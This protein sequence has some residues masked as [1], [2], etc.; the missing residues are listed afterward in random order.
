MKKS[1][2]HPDEKLVKAKFDI[3]GSKPE[4][5]ILTYEGYHFPGDTWNGWELPYFDK[6]T[7]ERLLKEAGYK[8]K[9]DNNQ[10]TIINEE[11]PDEPEIVT[12]IHF[13]VDGKQKTL[14]PFGM[15]WTWSLHNKMK[16]GGDVN[17]IY[18]KYNNPR[19]YFQSLRFSVSPTELRKIIIEDFKMEHISHQDLWEILNDQN[20]FSEAQAYQVYNA[21]GYDPPT[22]FPLEKPITKKED[23][24]N[25]PTSATLPTPKYRYLD[26]LTDTPERHELSIKDFGGRPR[27]YIVKK[28]REPE[29]GDLTYNKNANQYRYFVTGMIDKMPGEILGSFSG[30]ENDFQLY[31]PTK[32]ELSDLIQY[33][34]KR[35]DRAV[36]KSG[37]IEATK[38]ANDLKEKYADIL[39]QTQNT[40]P[41]ISQ[42]NKKS[43][44]DQY[45]VQEYSL[46]KYKPFETTPDDKTF[47][48]IHA[49]FAASDDSEAR[50]ALFG[51]NF[52]KYGTVSTDA[53]KLLFSKYNTPDLAKY[54]NYCHTEKCFRNADAVE[55]TKYP[56]WTQIIP[57]NH[58]IKWHINTSAM[59]NFLKNVIDLQLINQ[60]TKLVALTDGENTIG[61]NAKN[62]LVAIEALVKL[63]HTDLEIAWS[64]PTGAALIYPKGNASKIK[65]GFE[66]DGTI[67]T[68]TFDT[69]F[70][71][72]MPVVLSTSGSLLSGDQTY[73]QQDEPNFNVETNCVKLTADDAPYCFDL[74]EI[75]KNK[76]KA[77]ADRLEAE[78]KASQQQIQALKENTAELNNTLAAEKA[79][80]EAKKKALADAADLKRKQEIETK[81]LGNIEELA[82]KIKTKKQAQEA[83]A[84]ART[85]SPDEMA[86]TIAGN[87][88]ILEGMEEGPEKEALR[89]YNE[90]LRVMVDEEYVYAKGGTIDKIGN[91]KT[92][93][94]TDSGNRQVIGKAVGTY[95]GNTIYDRGPKE[96]VAFRFYM[97]GKPN[98]GYDKGPISANGNTLQNV[99]F[100]Y[101][102]PKD[103]FGS[104]DYA[105][106]GNIS[107]NIHSTFAK[108]VLKDY[109][110]TK[111]FR[112]IDI[113]GKN[114]IVFLADGD[115]D[116]GL[117]VTIDTVPIDKEKAY[118]IIDLAKKIP[119]SGELN[120]F[121]EN[122]YNDITNDI[123]GD[124]NTHDK[125]NV[126][127]HWYADY[128][129][130]QDEYYEQGGSVELTQKFKQ[131]D[132]V[133]DEEHKDYG[134][135]IDN[136]GDP[137]NGNGG[138]I[139]LDSD[140]NVNIYTYDKD[141]KRNGYNLIHYGQAGDNGDG[142][143]SSLKTGA[144]KMLEF[145]NP[146]RS[147][148]GTIY[149]R[150]LAG[151]FDK[152]SFKTGGKVSAKQAKED[153]SHLADVESRLVEG[154]I[155][156]DGKELSKKE[157]KDYILKNKQ[158]IIELGRE[159]YNPFDTFNRVEREK[160]NAN[161]KLKLQYQIK[162]IE[163]EIS[164]NNSMNPTKYASETAELEKQKAILEKQLGNFGKGGEIGDTKSAM[165]DISKIEH[166]V[167][168]SIRGNSHEIPYDSKMYDD[169]RLFL[170]DKEF[171]EKY[172]E[173][174]G[175]AMPDEDEF[176]ENGNMEEFRIT[177]RYFIEFKDYTHLT[178]DFSFDDDATLLDVNIP[179]ED[180]HNKSMA[181][182][183]YY[184]FEKDGWNMPINEMEEQVGKFKDGGDISG[185]DLDTVY[186]HYII[187]ALWSSTDEDDAAFDS[188]YSVE[189]VDPKTATK[190][191]ARIKQW[192]IDNASDLKESGLDDEQIG[193]DLW[194]T[195]VGHGAGFWDRDLDKE[196]GNRLSKAAKELGSSAYVYSENG[197]VYIDGA[198]YEEGGDVDNYASLLEK[199]IKPLVKKVVGK[200][201]N[202][203]MRELGYQGGGLN[204]DGKTIGIVLDNQYNYDIT[205]YLD[206]DQNGK[207]KKS[208]ITHTIKDWEYSIKDIEQVGGFEGTKS[209]WEKLC[210]E[211]GKVIARNP[212]AK[213]K[214]GEGGEIEDVSIWDDSELANY[215]GIEESV[216]QNDREGYEE[217]ATDLMREAKGFKTGGSVPE[218]KLVYDISYYTEDGEF[219]DET[220]IDEKNEQLAWELFAEFGHTKEP[221]MYIEWEPVTEEFKTGGKIPSY[222]KDWD[223]SEKS[224]KAIMKQMEYDKHMLPE[225]YAAVIS[226]DWKKTPSWFKRNLEQK[227][228]SDEDKKSPDKIAAIR[229]QLI[230][231]F[232]KLSKSKFA[233]DYAYTFSSDEEKV[234]WRIED[235]ET[236]KKYENDLA[237][238][239]IKKG[240]Y[241]A[242]LE[243]GTLANGGPVIKVPGGV[244][245]AA[246]KLVKF[247]DTAKDSPDLVKISIGEIPEKKE[248]LKT[249]NLLIKNKLDFGDKDGILKIK[250]W[251]ETFP[252]GIDNQYEGKTPGEVWDAWTKPQKAHFLKDH[253]DQ[254]RPKI[255][256]EDIEKYSDYEYKNLGLM[257][258]SWLEQHIY[259]GQYAK[260]GGIKG[261]IE[262]GTFL[263][264]STGVKVKVLEYD[265]A[266]GGRVKVERADGIISTT[267]AWRPL[268]NFS[269]TMPKEFNEDGSIRSISSGK[270]IESLHE[271]DSLQDKYTNIKKWND[272][273]VSDADIDGVL[274]ALIA[275]GITDKKL[276]TPPT[277]T[278]TQ[279][280]KALD[281]LAME[282]QTKMYKKYKGNL[283]G[284]QPYSIIHKIIENATR[285]N[286]KIIEL[287]KINK[288]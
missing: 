46:P 84:K 254:I 265:K 131:G 165:Q 224:R 13:M 140:G 240:R 226:K 89:T 102:N 71:L 287:Y 246:Q 26:I 213:N 195:Q 279:F 107:N 83:I 164:Y 243:D 74:V 153:A 237:D 180:D 271:E 9:F 45:V 285:Y 58:S 122:D 269:L 104:P 275:I 115:N 99:K 196:L 117:F 242:Y 125:I 23:G 8:Y 154:E 116:S 183:Y 69:D 113:T 257:F 108:Q 222:A 147:D 4:T 152:K 255:S 169:H 40:T 55:E 77:H 281:K 16:D 28:V 286:D 86:A 227:F 217:Q 10:F 203:F 233:N 166:V 142:N 178:L 136:Y 139:R 61:F 239:M 91:P 261:P 193:H 33:Y 92:D 130:D 205:T 167:D 187:A 220:Q 43:E 60:A 112:A 6:E 238:E 230:E 37:T 106:G 118:L 159:G 141:W 209:L 135:V 25:I 177:D 236:R 160:I 59:V 14:Y 124:F 121:T 191:K 264:A 27:F 128:I 268:K 157:A 66:Q 186:K 22:R 182:Q 156:I 2:N 110:F 41:M 260:G 223:T 105:E 80:A 123:F 76:A 210:T 133:W 208:V 231:K 93:I 90:G 273:Q 70:A 173:K 249:I 20:I 204:N 199:K 215:L 211:I 82:R 50:L 114:D 212:P 248:A 184:E 85:Y 198:K 270:Y 258:R 253:G 98:Q 52:S 39:N 214:F 244:K 127:K 218:P 68:Y 219:I 56:D 148:Y 190:I 49:K 162:E 95:K 32:E 259:L 179:E 263:Y 200:S 277:K 288:K 266:F 206:F 181:K 12:D 278:G 146:L 144:K 145:K 18:P 272:D 87:E 111:N 15:G 234:S 64:R 51:T 81:R 79:E 216:I 176:E 48:D 149:K 134:V 29:G 38:I 221:G 228:G 97:R 75:E 21:L 151:E 53:N 36:E 256:K 161:P 280:T 241:K 247:S 72:V 67:R 262:P 100:D 252:D 42:Q 73:V 232:S 284:N 158:R 175:C 229:K 94:H 24:G 3:P 245:H 34:E 202:E 283:Q 201:D 194:L 163:D 192:L 138:E 170:N 57:F 168:Y 185:F 171:L 11:Y 47:M 119:G 282:L 235:K 276:H 17:N 63:G 274:D 7:A 96:K 103:Y 267:S 150:L 172:H 65:T 250:T 54:G 30:Y 251:L 129:D 126:R 5:D 62:L 132:V 143:L 109:G 188:N 31:M 78:L 88:V 189:D 197:V 35:A 101:D 44:F 207:L 174:I 225:M 19:V 155:T 137:F 1:Y 120:V